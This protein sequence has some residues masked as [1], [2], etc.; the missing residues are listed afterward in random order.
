GAVARH[1]EVSGTVVLAEMLHRLP[2]LGQPALGDRVDRAGAAAVSDAR[3]V[4]AH[5]REPQPSQAAR[6][7]DVEALGP[8]AVDEPEFRI[9]TA[10]ASGRAE[11][12]AGSVTMPTSER[13]DPKR[14][15]DSLMAATG[16]AIRRCR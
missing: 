7:P 15:A 8:D 6:Q 11:P 9:R 3:E 12:A 16:S 14:T 2:H 5:A 13:V 10:G 1:E 4:D